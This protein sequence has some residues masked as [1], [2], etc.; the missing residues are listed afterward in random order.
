MAG[1]PLM[2]GL[3]MAETW[4]SDE[5]ET[6]E[7]DEVETWG[8]DGV[9]TWGSDEEETWGSDEVEI[10]GSD[11][12]ETP[13]TLQRWVGRARCILQSIGRGLR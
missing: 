9:E 1:L 6:W 7:S 2:A 5:V 4:G 3:L 13:A 8:S 10:W 12:V 11:E